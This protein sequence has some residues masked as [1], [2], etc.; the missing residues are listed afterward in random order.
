M[1]ELDRSDLT[2]GWPNG[3]KGMDDWVGEAE[4]CQWLSDQFAAQDLKV[5]GLASFTIRAFGLILLR[6]Q[7]D[8]KTGCLSY[9]R[10]L[11]YCEWWMTNSLNDQYLRPESS[12]EP[13]VIEHVEKEYGPCLR[14]LSND[15]DEEEGLFG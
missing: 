13:A 4:G 10:R 12:L 15:W 2:R 1:L 9:W 14:A 7:A 6:E 8:S 11:G 5:L 3:W